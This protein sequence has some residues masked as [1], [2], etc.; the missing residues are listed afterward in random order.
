MP[1]IKF[2]HAILLYLLAMAIV[3]FTTSE[4]FLPIAIAGGV[5]LIVARTPKLMTRLGTKIVAILVFVVLMI[6][7]VAFFMEIGEVDWISMLIMG[8]V[9]LVSAVIAE[10]LVG[11][12][13][14]RLVK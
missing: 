7:V 4:F 11:R 13:R 6:T 2:Q 5:L 10:A 8:V 12:A 9:L 14:A 3:I 1:R